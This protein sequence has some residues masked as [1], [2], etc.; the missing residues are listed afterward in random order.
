[1]N[2]F[3]KLSPEHLINLLPLRYNEEKLL[4]P[5]YL[6]LMNKKKLSFEQTELILLVSDLTKF[7]K[8]GG[9]KSLV[10]LLR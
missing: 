2:E 8:L 3:G 5:I 6:L 9:K 7:V 4:S 10:R 1:M